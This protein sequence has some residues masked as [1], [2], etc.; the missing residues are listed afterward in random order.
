MEV[1]F[2]DIKIGETY[3]I[4]YKG[5][6]PKITATC[7]LNRG[8]FGI[9][10]TKIAYVWNNENRTI[11]NQSTYYANVGYRFFILNQKEKIQDAME[12]RAYNKIMKNL[13]GHVI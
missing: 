2:K 6:Y 9:F 3:G 11:D 5:I 12:I 4:K 13:L 7:I 10:N 1:A 8:S